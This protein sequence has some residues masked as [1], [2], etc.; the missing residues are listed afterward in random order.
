MTR[1]AVERLRRRVTPCVY[2]TS[3]SGTKPGTP[4]DTC[5]ARGFSRPSKPVIR[6][7]R[8]VMMFV[9]IGRTRTNLV[10]RYDYAARVFGVF[11]RPKDVRKDDGNRRKSLPETL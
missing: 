3:S 5:F 6:D 11:G 4:P 9:R 7:R 8:Y 1:D 10:A 2:V